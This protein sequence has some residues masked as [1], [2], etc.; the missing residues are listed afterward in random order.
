M[1]SYLCFPSLWIIILL[2]LSL[3]HKIQRLHCHVLSF[4]VVIVFVQSLS[5]V[6]LFET[7]WNIARQTPLF[8]TI[9]CSLLK[10][11]SIELAMPS[12]HLILFCSLLLLPSIF[13]S[14]RF[15]PMSW[16]FTLSG[17]SIGNSASASVLPMNIQDRFPLRWTALI[18][19]LSK[20]LSTVLSTIW[21]PQFIST[22]PSL[23]SN[24]HIHTWLQKKS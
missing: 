22:Q 2:W 20:G 7:Q 11:V 4:F 19:L 23:W 17:Q 1:G 13:P 8:F 10:F 16:L 3:R 14:I 15:S 21:K 24:S 18:S 12:N 5:H 9:S 6:P